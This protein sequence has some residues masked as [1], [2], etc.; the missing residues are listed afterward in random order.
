MTRTEIE[1]ILRLAINAPSGENCQP[2][3]FKVSQNTISV[4]NDP[5]RDQSLYN[6]NQRGSLVAHGALIK[7]IKLSAAKYGYS[8]DVSILPDSSEQNCTAK[9]SFT[10][11]KNNNAGLAKY[12]LLRS[13]NRRPFKKQ[14]IPETQITELLNSSENIGN[15]KIF[16]TQEPEKISILA[17]ASSVNERVMFSNK[18]LHQFFFS[19]L[20]WTEN[21]EKTRRQGFYIKTLELPAPAVA[22]LKLMRHWNVIRF[23]NKLGFAKVVALGN[24]QTYAACAAMASIVIE[25][26][27][28]ANFIG[29]GEKMQHL[30]LT[31]TKLGLSL[32]LMT[33]VL[34]F[35]Q[36]IFQTDGNEFSV[37]Q[38][39]LIKH[40]YEDIKKTLGVTDGIVTLLFR[41]GYA[42]P[43]SA[44]SLKQEPRISFLQ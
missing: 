16:I 9:I 41:I 23:F 12:I 4:F 20:N 42:D 6:F 38:T 33:G 44:K 34:F 30:W 35:K 32:Q 39:K 31:A 27:S 5:E 11:D 25:N 8:A 21:E 10:E 29:A 26:D 15:G 3:Y 24:A 18:L 2:W 37:F 40:A 14:R 28:P 22:A 19:H 1:D 43:P 17:S 7:N 13:T 36:R